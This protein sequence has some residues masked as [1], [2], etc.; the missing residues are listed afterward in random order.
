MQLVSRY[1]PNV[2]KYWDTFQ[3]AIVETLIIVGVS[4]L[5]VI[6]IG[7]LLGI[8]LVI[9]DDGGICENKVLNKI[10]PKIINLIRAVPFVILLTMLMPFTRAIVGTAIGVKGAIVPLVVCLSP[11]VARQM[12]IAIHDV[13]PGVIEMAKAFGYSKPYIIFRIMLKE[14]R[15]GI[16]RV[17]ITSTIS[18]VNTSTMAGVIGGGG[19]GD[20]AIRYGYQRLMEDITWVSVIALL[21]LIFAIQGAGNLVL[22]RL[23]TS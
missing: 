22:K 19:I 1:F 5:L 10:V 9:I 12:E 4:V 15:E 8:L 16:I 17:I 14:T 3:E 7:L 13:D 2:V 23:S 21:I 11:F 20:F 6:S 18:V